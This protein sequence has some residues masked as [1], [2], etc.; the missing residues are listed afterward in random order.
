MEVRE[1]LRQAAQRYP[2]RV[3]VIDEGRATTFA[4][5]W[6]RGCRLA[7]G[8][9]ALGLRAGDRIGVLDEN[10]LASVDAFLGA[11]IANVVRVPLY[12][13]NSRESHRYM[14]EHTGCRAVIVDQDLADSVAGL[15]AEVPGLETVLVRDDKYESWLAKFNSGDPD[16]AIEPADLFVIRHTGGTSG[17][18]KGV[19]YTHRSWIDA[20]TLVFFNLPPVLLGDRCLHVAPISHGSGY[21][22]LPIWAS[23]GVNIMHRRF[24]PEQVLDTIARDRVGY[25][26][27]VSTMLASMVDAPRAGE[28]DL[29]SV[30]ALMLGGAPVSDATALRAHDLFGD[31]LF[32]GYGQTEV[33]F[34]TMMPSAEWFGALPGSVPLRSAGRAMPLASIQIVDDDGCP[35]PAGETGEI[36]LRS[37][38]QLAAFWNDPETTAKRIVNG[39]IRTND[40][41]HLDANGYLYVTD[42]KDDMIISGGFNIWPR[43]LEQVIEELPGVAEVTVFGIPDERWGETPLALC[44]LESGAE[45]TAAEIA[46][47]C[48]QALGSYKK[49]GR[50][51]FS[52][53]PLPKTPVGKIDRKRLR[54]PY[55]AHSFRHVS[56]R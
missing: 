13:R 38:A 51:E 31:A 48:A 23:G 3:A 41:G 4:E 26:F 11:A 54:E 52:T 47:A 33:C 24:E 25:V 21:M 5:A 27:V 32:Q 46:D 35:L 15:E 50:V 6:A 8:L 10:S 14:L 9:L 19:P 22:F 17:R 34:V 2:D 29:S 28:R 36:A 16:P 1:L 45:L 56:G 40:V 39:W 42:R 18:P 12:P 55:W 37:V 20:S 44:R 7:N 43:E 30:K 53:G 49:P